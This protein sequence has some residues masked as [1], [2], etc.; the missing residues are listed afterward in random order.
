MISGPERYFADF[1][2]PSV[3][4]G[5]VIDWNFADFGVPI[6]EDR[7]VI[8]WNFAPDIGGGGWPDINIGGGWPDINIALPIG[9]AGGAPRPPDVKQA[10]TRITDA[11]AA[12][13]EANLRAYQAGQVDASSAAARAWDIFNRWLQQVLQYGSQGRIT[14][15]ERDRRLNSPRL[16]WDWIAYY[17][18]PIP[19]AGAA[20]GATAP[21]TQ[22]P[23]TTP[24][25]PVYAGPGFGGMNSD[26]L[27][28]GAVA[29]AA[30]LLLRRRGK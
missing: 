12:A 15:E 25:G 3:E 8:D 23:G 4:D 24:G 5:T 13:L 27:L 16:R 18:D 29:V 28:I 9:G 19:G 22:P 14:A 17:I 11:S 30:V 20:P 21:V 1:G 26:W 6:L 10:L 2:V 7:T